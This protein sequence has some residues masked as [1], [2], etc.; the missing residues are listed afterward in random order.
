[1]TNL[2]Y[3]EHYTYQ[4][5]VNWEGDWELINGIAYA[6]APAPMKKHQSIN[7]LITQQ[8]AHWY[9][10]CLECEVLIEADYKISEDT[11]VRPDISVVC[12]DKSEAY[13][14]K[15]PEIIVEIISLN[16]AKRDENIK[17]ELYQIERVKYYVLVYPNELKAK[18]FKHNG[19]RFIKEGDFFDEVYEFSDAKCKPKIDFN[20]V[21]KRYRG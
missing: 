1:M 6:M 4:D 16:T 14:A 15:A 7:V 21:F 13:I 18:I 11:V 19:I 9:E 8:L 20:K 12:N 10:D 3:I 17:F 5:Y 2:A